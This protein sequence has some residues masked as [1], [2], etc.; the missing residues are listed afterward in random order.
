MISDQKRTPSEMI[1]RKPI[2]LL[3]VSDLAA[4]PIWKFENRDELGE[5]SVRAVEVVPV[6]NL[7]GMIIGTQVRLANGDQKCALLGNIRTGESAIDGALL[8]LQDRAQRARGSVSHG[9]ST[10]TIQ[11]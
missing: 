6:Q 4:N 2:E 10:L 3:T 8:D 5:T 7:D 9:I 11:D 1:I